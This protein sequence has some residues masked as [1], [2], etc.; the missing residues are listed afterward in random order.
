MQCPQCHSQESRK[1]GL[2]RHKR[3]RWQC[4]QCKRTYGD[5]DLR[6]VD[7]K[8]KAKALQLYAEGNA[9]RRIERIEKVSHNSVLNWVR[10]EVQAKALE[11]VPEQELGVVEI[12]EMWSFVGSKKDPS[13]CG[14]R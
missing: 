7:P 6:L 8:I 13:G 14:G 10:E 2:S 5:G 9:A 3:Q 11:R 12:D 4:K 1:I